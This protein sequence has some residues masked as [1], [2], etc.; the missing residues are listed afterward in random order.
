MKA[1]HKQPVKQRPEKRIGKTHHSFYGTEISEEAWQ[2]LNFMYRT[3]S[4]KPLQIR[5]ETL[6]D[7]FVIASWRTGIRAMPISK[8]VFDE[9]INKR[10]ISHNPCDLP[11][12][13]GWYWLVK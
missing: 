6:N 13:D 3:E 1:D 9:L 2:A 7:Q 8:Q 11:M 4:K 12:G 10:F 5:Y